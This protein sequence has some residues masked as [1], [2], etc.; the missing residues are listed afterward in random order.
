[1]LVPASLGTVLRPGRAP[2]RRATLNLSI[3][4]ASLLVL[5]GTTLAI[6]LRPGSWFEREYDGRAVHT[7]A[8]AVAHDPGIKIFADIRYSDW[9]LWHDPGL[10]GHLAY[11]TR[12]EL[13]TNHQILALAGLT[14]L[15][16]PHQ[17]SILAGY[18]LLVLDPTDQPKTRI[19]L[20]HPGTRVIMRGKRVIVA[21]AS[22]S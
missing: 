11:D 21:T 17:R 13:L 15:P 18:K 8:E 6:A 3:A 4:G 5:A 16:E 2:E 22:G 1:M 20:A 19:L 10:A 9:L 14:Q 12:L 7:V